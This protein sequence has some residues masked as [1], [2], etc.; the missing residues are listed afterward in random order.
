MWSLL[1]GL[2]C[3]VMTLLW[4]ASSSG[5]IIPD[6]TMPITMSSTNA[7]R[8]S[9]YNFTM[10]LETN[11]VPGC[12]IDIL[13]PSQQY[14]DGLGLDYNF[15]V[16]S[17]TS[18]QITASVSGTKISVEPG[19]RDNMT[20]IIITVKGILNPANVGGTSMFKA[21]YQ[22]N[23]NIIDICENFASIAVTNPVDKLFASDAMVEQGSSSIAGEISN[24][25][26]NF[27]PANDLNQNTV[28]KVTFPSYYNFTYLRTLVED[29]PSKNP[30][31]VVA[32]NTTGFILNGNITCK[33]SDVSDNIIEWYGNNQVIP[34]QSSIW[35]KLQNVY[36]PTREM[37]TDFLT[38]EVNLKNTN[39]TYE[40][41]DAVEGLVIVPGPIS[42]FR[43]TPV[44]QLPLEKMFPYDFFISFTPTNSFQS[45]RI[46]TRFRLINSCV[47]KN[48]LLPLTL[49]SSIKCNIN[50]NILEVNN[51]Q[52][53]IRKYQTNADKITIKVNA[54]T[55]D[56]SGTQIPFEIYTYQNSDFTIKVDQNLTSTDTVMYITTS[57]MLILTKHLFNL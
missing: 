30:C 44:L 24:Y 15:Q 42:G 33:F 54:K 2:T 23:G 13:F 12:F 56:Q 41:N 38:V 6:K 31:L 46:V 40:Y 16:F 55:P 53:Y 20:D 39:F 4:G 26:I 8:N 25:L 47:I 34:K 19:Y 3:V 22:C 52:A 10:K 57:R 9:D 5:K 50:S 11:T 48:S 51:I 37:N 35:L 1:H 18:N 32:D 43:V 45:L 36:N 17:P 29:F 28:F 27:K 49:D 14:I 7:L 21:Y